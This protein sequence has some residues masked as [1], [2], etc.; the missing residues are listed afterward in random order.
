MS[1]SVKTAA[2]L[3]TEFADGQAA[4]SIVPGDVRDLIASIG[5][6]AGTINQVPIYQIG[7]A[8]TAVTVTPSN[9]HLQE[10]A[11]N[12]ASQCTITIGSGNLVANTRIKMEL[13]LVQN[14]NGTGSVAW[15]GVGF[16]GAPPQVPPVANVVTMVELI[17]ID[18]GSTWN[19]V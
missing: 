7:N 15:S 14:S 17:S 13:Y 5:A 9:G 3:Y 4:G 8:G 19:G 6:I 11:L 18:G 10:M 1:G 2:Q 12:S 16:K